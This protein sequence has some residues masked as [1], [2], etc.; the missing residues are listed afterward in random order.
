MLLIEK[1]IFI[2]LPLQDVTLFKYLERALEPRLAKGETSVRF[3]VTE[4]TSEGWN[5]E[6]GV[7]TNADELGKKIPI[8]NFEKRKYE[9][10]DSFNAVMLVPTGIGA[11]IGGHAGDATPAARL[12]AGVCDKLIIHP[13][14]VNASDI[15]EMPENGLY[16]EGSVISR[17]LMGTVGLQETRSNRVLLVIDE[18]T[19]KRVAE[20]AINAA[21]AARLR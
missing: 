17:L 14:V 15:N 5:C 3:A 4:S 13:N 9:S 1:E 12:L 20:L 16:V 2:Q 18:H 6:I 10:T 21:S 11:E 7:L 8:F 19:D